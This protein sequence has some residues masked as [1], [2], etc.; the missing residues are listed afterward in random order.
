MFPE[1]ISFYDQQLT[2][3]PKVINI[4][5]RRGIDLAA[6]IPVASVARS[7]HS[8]ANHLSRNGFQVGGPAEPC[9]EVDKWNCEIAVI[10][11]KLGDLVV[12]WIHVLA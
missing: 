9:E 5:H 1:I 8:L 12:P 10:L 11:G 2:K 3:A 7:H 4:S 6:R